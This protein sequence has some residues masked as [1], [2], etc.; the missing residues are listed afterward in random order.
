M[1]MARRPV[2]ASA[3]VTGGV[4]VALQ[5]MASSLV[6]LGVE[7]G[8]PL[9]VADRI[10]DLAVNALTLLAAFGIV[11][12]SESRVTPVDDPRDNDGNLLVSVPPPPK[13]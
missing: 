2:L 11:R 9:G 13:S 5:N 1:G 3:S 6:D 4:A 10:E 7:L 8:L 12:Y